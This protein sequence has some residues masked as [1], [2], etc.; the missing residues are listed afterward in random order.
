MGGRRRRKPEI[1]VRVPVAPRNGVVAPRGERL[2]GRQEVEG[3]SPSGSTTFVRPSGPRERGA[4]SVSTRQ[5]VQ[6]PSTAPPE[7]GP[8]RGMMKG[9]EA[10]GAPVRCQRTPKRVRFSSVPP[11]KDRGVCSRRATGLPSQRDGFES[12]TP[13]QAAIMSNGKTPRC[14]RGDT[15][16]TPVGCSIGL[17]RWSAL[18][19]QPEGREF[20]SLRALCASWHALVV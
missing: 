9:S 19:L 17:V 11:E 14:P 13:L 12:R 8:I 15:G 4:C 6:L 16:S 3:A 5:W 18:R 2:S 20:D 10:L 1:R 7:G